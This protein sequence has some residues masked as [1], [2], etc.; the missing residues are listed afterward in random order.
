MEDP[1]GAALAALT[2]KV[3]ELSAIC[4]GL[5]SEN[6]ELREQMS[7]LQAQAALSPVGVG[8]PAGLGVA[9]VPGPSGSGVPAGPGVAVAR[10][11]SGP[12]VA[13][14]PSLPGSGHAR[15]SAAGGRRAGGGRAGGGAA[16]SGTAGGSAAG[17]AGTRRNRTD[18]GGASRV[19]TADGP[20]SRRRVVGRAVGAVA[21]S[22]VASA[23]FVDLGAK[24]ADASDGNSVLAGDVTTAEQRTSV[25]YDGSSNFGGV[26]LLGND[27]TYGGQEA[28]YPAALGGWAGAGAT[29]GKGGVANGIY[30]YSDNGNGYGVCAINGGLVAGSGGGLLATATGT[31]AVAVRASSND[32]TAVAGTSGSTDG[33]ATAV[34]GTISS[35]S[36]GG[37]S[38]AVRGVNNGTGGNGIGAWGS[39]GGSG[40]GVYGSS[41][42]GLGV[43]GAG[44]SGVGVTGSG[45]SAG[46]EANGGAIGLSASGITAV[47]AAGET[48][49][50]V[51]TASGSTANG[52]SSTVK[53]SNAALLGTNNGGTGAGVHGSSTTGRGGN[54]VGGAAQIRL[55]PGTRASHPTSGQSGDL[56]ADK[57]GR[58]WFCKK[59]G[60]HATWHQIA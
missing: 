20:I 51:V 14:V 3:Q 28:T 22:A 12:G 33:E 54:F 57:N 17:G 60:S 39:H 53:S 11:V 37:F 23:A 32:G 48:A 41:L 58:L 42:S 43:F 34:V 31:S 29:A 8:V 56:Y 40:W 18:R 49:G 55:T 26:V 2:V 5:S 36:P 24:P 4:A 15:S 50:I 27:S 44:G 16:G 7:R 13:L 1:S 6:S 10:G 52:V 35:I 19:P 30:G 47:R 59:G 45:G 46:V 38:A 21:A 25:L 9:V